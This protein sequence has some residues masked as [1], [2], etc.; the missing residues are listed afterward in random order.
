[1]RKE[2]VDFIGSMNEDDQRELIALY[3]IGGVDFPV[4]ERPGA[5]AEAA[6]RGPWTAAFLIVMPNAAGQLEPELAIFGFS[7]EDGRL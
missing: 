2:L 7:R 4:E 5:L 3:L 1:V 6:H